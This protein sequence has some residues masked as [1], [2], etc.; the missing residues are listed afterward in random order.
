M[1]I[2]PAYPVNGSSS[3]N[4]N[5]GRVPTPSTVAGIEAVSL[6]W[7]APSTIDPIIG[8]QV[9][10]KLNADVD[11]TV[12]DV[13][14]ALTYSVVALEGGQLYDFQVQAYTGVNFGAFSPT[15]SDTPTAISAPKIVEWNEI[16]ADTA[17]PIEF[18]NNSGTGGAQYNLDTKVGDP[19]DTANM[20]P[21]VSLNGFNCWQ[22][23]GG[24]GIR[25]S[26]PPAAITQPFTFAFCFLPFFTDANEKYIF[27]GAFSGGS[28]RITSTQT[29][30]NA[31]TVLTAPTGID[32]DGDEYIVLCVADGLNSSIRIIKNDGATDIEIT[33]DAGL[34][35]IN[36]EILLWD[37]AQTTGLDAALQFY[38]G[39]FYQGATTPEERDSIVL[40]LQTK[41]FTPPEA[42]Q[43]M[44]AAPPGQIS[45][46]I[47]GA[48]V[49]GVLP[50]ISTVLVNSLT[51]LPDPVSNAITLSPNTHYHFSNGV[52]LGV[53]RLI[54][55]DGV[56]LSGEGVYGTGILYE[57]TGDFLTAL[58]IGFTIDN[59][60]ST[61][62]NAN[63]VLNV[64]GTFTNSM[65]ADR[66]RIYDSTK[67]GSFDGAAMVMNNFVA[68]RFTQGFSF[69]GAPIIGHSIVNAFL[70][71]IDAGAIHFDFADGLFLQLAMEGVEMDGLGTCFASS[72]GGSGNMLLGTD[73]AINNCT[74]GIQATMTPLSGFIDGFQTIGWEFNN[75]S[76]SFVTERSREAVDHYLLS[77]NTI[78]V[79]SSGIWY[80]MGIPSV[81]SWQSDISD[82]FTV[83][84]DGSVTYN[85]NKSINV[86]ITCTCTLEQAG[87]GAD[88]LLQGIAINWVPNN[89]PLGKSV[90]GTENSQPTQLVSIAETE[91]SPNDN[92]RP[93]YLNND[94]SSNII[95]DRIYMLINEAG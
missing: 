35:D 51:N 31:G 32:F 45:L 44:P 89:P 69:T 14:L 37:F 57:G 39:V 95:V 59:L 76:P 1:P 53:N 22:S 93:V 4:D 83:N 80:E 90:V 24:A 81:G 87:G 82:R 40:K 6:S 20:V 55:S 70:Q 18:V 56:Q 79:G 12:I 36:P 85:G 72:V 48:W 75:N 21:I 50:T 15:A 38:E 46:A 91:I 3:E 78:T 67:L 33:G 29:I 60:A 68:N 41:W 71:D 11:W 92:I 16:G 63:Q 74:M 5:P 65:F 26:A 2:F 28:L 58:N 47:G 62:P 64:T 86:L 54:L 42:T 10:F 30:L 7:S 84:S 9:R 25:T 66:F 52:N 8:Y 94:D 73:A 88:L 49:S 19:A 23:S 27:E 13:G 43:F 17:N 77:Q 34:N 61:C